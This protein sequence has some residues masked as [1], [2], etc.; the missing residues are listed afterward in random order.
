M[1]KV[2]DKDDVRNVIRTKMLEAIENIGIET[3]NNNELIK[4][5]SERKISNK[6]FDKK[7][8]ELDKSVNYFRGY[9]AACKDV[10]VALGEIL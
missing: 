7:V 10:Y 3:Q 1:S 6:E 2:I 9:M 4:L 8:K 5:L